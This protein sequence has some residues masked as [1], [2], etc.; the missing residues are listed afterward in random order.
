MTVT[1]RVEAILNYSNQAR[2]SDT[3]L[4][5]I[6]M[7][8]SGMNLTPEQVAVFK[9]ELPSFETITRIRRKLQEQ[10]KYEATNEVNEARYKKFNAMKN[11]TKTAQHVEKVLEDGTIVLPDG[12][13]VL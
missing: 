13:I 2:N 6:Y 1:Q 5:L 7:Q 3:E 12:R 10:G 8:K 11:Q 9:Q 4:F